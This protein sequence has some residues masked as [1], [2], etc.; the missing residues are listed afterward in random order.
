MISVAAEL[1]PITSGMLF[2]QIERE[3]TIYRVFIT[4]ESWEPFQCLRPRPQFAHIHLV[5]L[6]VGASQPLVTGV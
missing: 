5:P 6:A 2:H 1:Q 3:L 4:W